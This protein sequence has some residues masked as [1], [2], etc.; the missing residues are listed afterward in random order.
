MQS[1]VF[2]QKV[3]AYIRRVS[4]RVS[5]DVIEWFHVSVGL[6]QGCVMSPWLFTVYMDGVVR[7]ANNIVLGRQTEHVWQEVW[8]KSAFVCREV[9]Y[10]V[11]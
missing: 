11:E 9:M 8:I 7:E 2:I 1:C 4:D 6:R 10:T 5:G 3:A